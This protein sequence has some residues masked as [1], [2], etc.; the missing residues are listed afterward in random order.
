MESFKDLQQNPFSA[1]VL[2]VV[3]VFFVL[4]GLY[5]SWSLPMAVILVVP[6]CLSSALAGVWLAGMDVNIFVQVGFV[7]LVGLAAKNAILIVEFARDRQKEGVPLDEAAVEAARVRLR[8]IIMTSFAFILGVL[9][10]VISHGAGAE[11]RRTLGTAVFSGHAGRDDVRHLSDARVLLRRAAADAAFAHSASRTGV[12]R[13]V[14]SLTWAGADFARV[15][16]GPSSWCKTRWFCTTR[17]AGLPGN[18]E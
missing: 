12:D 17:D 16:G 1:F 15:L 14:R 10:L 4:A 11:M 6:M 8:P 5:E 2:G 13:Q 7:V 18:H 9:P 3:L